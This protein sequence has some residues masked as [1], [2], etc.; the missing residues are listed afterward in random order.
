MTDAYIFW[1]LVSRVVVPLVLVFI[2][3]ALIVLKDEGVI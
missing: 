3:V 2:V 1:Q